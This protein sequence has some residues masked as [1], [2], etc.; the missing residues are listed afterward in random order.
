M[1]LFA[2]IVVNS[3]LV[4]LGVLIH[5]ET[6]YQLARHIPHLPVRPRYRVLWGVVFILIAHIVEIW[7][8]A[9][10]YWSLLH[11]EGF[12]HLSGNIEGPSLLECSYFSF[13]TFTTVGYG[14]IVA[15]G[16][17]RYLTGLEALTGMVLITWSASFLFLEMQ[18]NWMGPHG[19]RDPRDRTHHHSGH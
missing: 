12:G 16:Y 13:V 15:S 4:G 6:L 17:L 7:L 18:R 9:L 1:L 3:L 5:Y 2:I 19:H 11:V 14:D 10:G 8:F